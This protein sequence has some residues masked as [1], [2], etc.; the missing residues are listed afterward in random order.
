MPVHEILNER[1]ISNIDILQLL[2]H[3][4]KSAFGRGREFQ[5]MT[6]PWKLV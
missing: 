3:N 2:L 6:L 5:I 1:F 4:K